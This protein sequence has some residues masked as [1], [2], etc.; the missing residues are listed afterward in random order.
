LPILL[1]DPFTQVPQA[2]IWRAIC[3]KAGNSGFF[4]AGRKG[5]AVAVA[6]IVRL[7]GGYLAGGRDRVWLEPDELR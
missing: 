1:V 6:T 3:S 7:D 4:A 5:L 2:G